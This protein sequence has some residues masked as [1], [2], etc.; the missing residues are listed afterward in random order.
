[1]SKLRPNSELIQIIKNK[2]VKV[3]I[4]YKYF[5]LISRSTIKCQ[6]NIQDGRYQ[7]I[8]DGRI[9]LYRMVN[10]VILKIVFRSRI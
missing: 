8:F 6:Q 4:T 9:L 3:T 5:K 2:H 7:A 1:M 10:D